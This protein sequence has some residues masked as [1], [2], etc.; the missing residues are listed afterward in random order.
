MNKIFKFIG[1]VLGCSG[2]LAWFAM[3]FYHTTN[4]Y[5]SF[6]GKIRDLSLLGWGCILVLWGCGLFCLK[7]GTIK[8][9]VFAA[10]TSVLCFVF[11]CY[12]FYIYLK[13]ENCLRCMQAV[14]ALLIIG[15]VISGFRKKRFW[16]IK[17]FA[18][19]IFGILFST[20]NSIKL[21]TL[22]NAFS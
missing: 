14:L 2:A 17:L 5:F 11:D 15:A 13:D 6:A 10:A 21:A 1:Q 20:K 7:K 18:R 9:I 4:D 22:L 12:R 8:V 3:L 19:C 16:A